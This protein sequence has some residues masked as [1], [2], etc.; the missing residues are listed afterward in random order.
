MHAAP[1]RL[2]PDGLGGE[3]RALVR[4]RGELGGGEVGG[5]ARDRD[6]LV[7]VRRLAARADR[8]DRLAV[9][10]QRDAARQA[11]GA[12]ERER[13]QACVRYSERRGVSGRD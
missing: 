2:G 9:D 1:R 13:A 12:V 10:L 3:S 5:G 8:A 4:E 11:A 6:R 7:L